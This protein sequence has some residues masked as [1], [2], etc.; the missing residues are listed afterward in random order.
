MNTLCLLAEAS[1]GAFVNSAI[2]CAMGSLLCNPIA[3]V[4]AGGLIGVMCASVMKE[5][6][7]LLTPQQPS[8]VLKFKRRSV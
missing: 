7:K 3:I 2:A 6:L 5:T 8:K 1:V 4:C